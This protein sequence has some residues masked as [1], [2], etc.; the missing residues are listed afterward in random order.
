MQKK[1]RVFHR[2]WW[3]KNPA[4]P[5]GREPHAGKATHIGYADTIQQAQDMCRVWNANHDP[6]PLSRKAEFEEI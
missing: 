1:Y 5:N 4:Y 3:K 6:G 2:T